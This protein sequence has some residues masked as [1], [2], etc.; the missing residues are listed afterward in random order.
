MNHSGLFEHPEE[1]NTFSEFK[2]LFK[3]IFIFLLFSF[4]FLLNALLGCCENVSEVN[5]FFIF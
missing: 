2:Y 1:A 5:K 4:F 3:G